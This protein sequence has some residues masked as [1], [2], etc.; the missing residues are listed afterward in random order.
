MNKISLRNRRRGCDCNWLTTAAS[1]DLFFGTAY[2]FDYLLSYLFTSVV[3]TRRIHHNSR[4]FKH[5][6]PLPG[7]RCA[8]VGTRRHG[9]HEWKLRCSAGGVIDWTAVGRQCSGEGARL[10][11]Q[12]PP[13]PPPPPLTTTTTS[14]RQPATRAECIIVNNVC[15]TESV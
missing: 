12:P 10:F 1:S 2:K 11:K 6:G 13:P 9:R 4:G 15:F 7:S 5:P 3:F 14:A 8:P